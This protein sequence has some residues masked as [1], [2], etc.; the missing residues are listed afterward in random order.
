ML[1]EGNSKTLRGIAGKLTGKDYNNPTVDYPQQELDDALNMLTDKVYLYDHKLDKTWDSIRA[2]IRYMVLVEGI[3]D[4]ILDPISNLTAH[5]TTSEANEALN[6]HLTTSE[7]NEALNAIFGEVASMA[8]AMQFTLYYSSHLNL[9]E[10]GAPHEEG[11]RV[12]AS[13]FTGSRAMIKNSH[14][15]IGIERNT[16]AED[17]LLRNTSTIRLLKDRENGNTGFFTCFYDKEKRT[18]L[19]PEYNSKTEEGQE[20]Y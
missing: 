1:E 19:E 9:P 5:L 8:D 14:Y 11:G 17:E 6:A 16:Q 7:A 13:Q 12:K 4:I 2:E 15:I 20:K 10:S 3:R 18:F